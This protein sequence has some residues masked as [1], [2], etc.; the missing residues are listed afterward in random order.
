[1]TAIANRSP[2]PRGRVSKKAEDVAPRGPSTDVL[3]DI[4]FAPDAVYLL[5][6]GVDALANAVRPTLGPNVRSVA[7]APIWGENKPPE[8]LDD[9]AT[10]AR[11]IIEIPNPH[12]NMG[13]ML[14]RQ[15]LWNMH[16]KVGDGGA[17]TA[18]LMQALLQE[19]IRLSTAGWNV[20]TMRHGIEKATERAL[21]V[22]RGLARPIET[23]NDVI[24]LAFAASGDEDL[25]R[26]LGEMFDTLGADGHVQVQQ[27]YKP[28]L[29][30]EYIEGAYW[31]SGW[32][33]NLFANN[34]LQNECR[35]LNT[36]VL[37]ARG[38][39]E[40]WE[41][42]SPLLN[43]MAEQKDVALFI[44]ALDVSNTALNLLL[45][46]KEKVP[47]VAVK[48][49]SIG[50]HME[51]QLHDIAVL[52][53]TRVVLNNMGESLAKLRMADLGFARSVTANRDYF[54]IVGGN[55]DP[56]LLREHIALLRTHIRSTDVND[57]EVLGQLRQR[58]A[59]LVSGIGVIYVGG[60]TESEGNARRER[61]ERTVNTVKQAQA[62]GVVPGGG[63]A[64]ITA[65]KVLHDLR[66]PA[67]EAVGADVLMRA[68]EEPLRAIALNS[69]VAAGPIIG[70][71]FEQPDG[72]GYNALS[73]QF[74]DMRAAGIVDPLP[75]VEAA[76]ER[77]VSGA[78][79]ALTTH[80]T[81]H[82][83]NPP[84]STNP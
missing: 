81:V 43:E 55:S 27:G 57:S 41:D 34:D 65:A 9:A 33:S 12:A 17:T 70:Q 82:R 28:G 25:A 5:Q 38:R 66:L 58:L 64:Y 77:A 62:G 52:T 53:G 61:V 40:Q 29:M 71:A 16:E 7:M 75:V 60:A 59:K 31:D 18:V 37:V 63:M 45:S 4:K 26:R 83:R 79:M 56:R 44:V 80:V 1:M 51:N 47:C 54:G 23:E 46:N 35:L 6:R 22:I 78:L 13:A 8:L 19:G 15:V 42:L 48:A 76:L 67:E 3:P 68:L 50:E 84:L 21:A 14:L 72:W 73:D 36:H 49:P 74:E 69:G 2:I 11:R 10:I 30:H 24:G 39:I 32:V 20:M